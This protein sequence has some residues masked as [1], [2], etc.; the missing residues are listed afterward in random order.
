MAGT[1]TKVRPITKK[2]AQAA[3]RFVERRYAGCFSPDAMLGD[4]P[5]LKEPG[6][7]TEGWCIAW[8][9]HYDW[10]IEVSPDVTENVPGVFAEP[11][12]GWCLGLYP[13]R[14]WS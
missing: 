10:A 14:D 5:F 2:Q 11:V 8:E 4:R 6:T 7:E 1:W 9:G 12:A 3:L 13:D